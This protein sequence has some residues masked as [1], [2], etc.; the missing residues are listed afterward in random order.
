MLRHD[1][2]AWAAN[3]YLTMRERTDMAKQNDEPQTVVKHAIELTKQSKRRLNESK[4]NQQLKSIIDRGMGGGRMQR[5]WS[6]EIANKADLYTPRLVPNTGEYRYICKLSLVNTPKRKREESAIKQEFDS[7]IKF[8]STA[9]NVPGW[10]ILTID[11]KM[12]DTS[13][14]ERIQK[15]VGYVAVEIPSDWREQFSHIYE[16]DDQIDILMS[17]IRAGVDS[18]FQDRFHCAL[19]GPPACGKTETLRTVKKI[20]GEEA[21]LEY[22]ATAT[23]QAGAIKDL[24]MRLDLPRILIVEEIEKTDENSLRWLLSVMDHRAEIRKTTAR[25]SIQRETKLLTLATVN[26]Y[27]LFKKIMFGALA[28]RFTHHLYFPKPNRDLLKRILEREIERVKGKR[29]WIKP[30][31]DYAEEENITDPRKVSAI[32][33]CGRDAL[34]DGSYQEKLTQTSTKKFMEQLKAEEKADKD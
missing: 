17:A 30:T 14:D 25:E 3:A 1:R 8:I 15:P 12:V 20:L 27:K 34:L 32:C 5:G 28:S 26:D 7:I 11:N 21:V 6:I 4:I 16:R 18:N 2:P 19:V 23:T 31:L 10:E 33:L 13:K 29:A 9:G 24:D 22:D